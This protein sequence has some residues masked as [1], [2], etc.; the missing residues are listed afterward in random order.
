MR[1]TCPSR[2]P[3]SATGFPAGAHLYLLPCAK[4]ISAPGAARLREL[5]EGG[6]TVYASYFAGTTDRQ[7]GPWFPWVDEIFGVRHHLRYGLV[8]PIE[9]DE[10]VLEF[11]VPFGGIAPGGRLAF[12]VGGVA[13]SRAYLPV[14]ADGAEVLAVD[15]HGSPALLRRRGSALARRCCARTRWSTWRRERRG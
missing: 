8:D 10:V 3:A 12:R 4:L 15:Q 2:W 6:A 14:D 11:T 9:V 5:A 7:R 13:G 1:R